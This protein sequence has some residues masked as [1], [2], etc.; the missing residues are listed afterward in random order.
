MSH[1][2]IPLYK[3]FQG[4]SLNGDVTK[5]FSTFVFEGPFFHGDTQTV[6]YY[7]YINQCIL[8]TGAANAGC[9][10]EVD[11]CIWENNSE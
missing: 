10:G 7:Q 2:P 5:C 9:I 11:L 1:F 3:L 8:C 6:L 4:L